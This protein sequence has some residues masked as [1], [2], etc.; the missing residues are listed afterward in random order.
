M[1]RFEELCEAFRQYRADGV[2]YR[3]RSLSFITQLLTGFERYLGAPPGRVRFLPPESPESNATYNPA[4]AA[5][6]GEDGRWVV[7][8]RLTLT[9]GNGVYPELP[10]LFRFRVL[11]ELDK[12]TVRL[13][14]SNRTHTIPDG[15]DLTL[16]EPIYE[17]AYR[18]ASEYLTLG[19]QRFLDEAGKDAPREIGFTAGLN[20]KER[21][22]GCCS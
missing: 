10:L 12:F 5:K 18:R 2:A 22:S 1:T 3:D 14:D 13:G 20:L 9:E 21:S 6:L 4:G 19:L 17:E 7:N 8:V 16:L 15:A 11:V